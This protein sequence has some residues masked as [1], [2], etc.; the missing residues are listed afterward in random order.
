M[1]VDLVQ[2][3]FEAETSGLVKTEAGLDKVTAAAGRVDA[4]MKKAGDGVAASVSQAGQKFDALNAEIARTKAQAEALAKVKVDPVG[5]AVADSMA[6]FSGATAQAGQAA[7][8]T[9]TQM[10][11][12]TFQAN[13]VFTSIA[14]GAPAMQVLAQQGGQ[15]YQA[16]SMGPGGAGGAIRALSA[17]V[18]RFAVSGPG[19]F[20]AAALSVGAY[21][22]AIE[23]A[24]A[25]QEKLEKQLS[26]GMGRFAGVTADQFR[27]I[28]SAAASASGI[29]RGV[30]RDVGMV[31]AQTG[32]VGGQMLGDLISL[33]KRYAQTTGKEMT[34]AA[35]DI[36]K[37]FTD[38][39][40]GAEQ[41][42][43]TLGASTDFLALKTRDY[44]KALVAQGEFTK[45]QS[46]LFNELA[47]GPMPKLETRVK[48]L[49]TLWER[50]KTAASN[51][52]DSMVRAVVTTPEDRS[53]ELQS[54][55]LGLNKSPVYDVRRSKMQQEL[56][57]LYNDIDD[58]DAKLLA[59]TKARD[60]ELAA[61][62]QKA[63]QQRA[64]AHALEMRAIAAK[65]DVER[66][67][68]AGLQAYN[69]AIEQG[70]GPQAAKVMQINAEEKAYAGLIASINQSIEGYRL[71]A[72]AL[73]A[74]AR[75]F[76]SGGGMARANA[77]MQEANVL[78]KVSA[79]ITAAQQQ[80]DKASGDEK[81][82]LMQRVEELTKKYGEYSVALEQAKVA[83]DR[84]TAAA[85]TSNQE[86]RLEM[87]NLEIRTLNS[88][89]EA[90]YRK[91]EALKT[92]QWIANNMINGNSA[93]AD[94]V[95]ALS[96]AIVDK[97]LKLD[98]ARSSVDSYVDSLSKLKTAAIGAGSALQT[99]FAA[100]FSGAGGAQTS[101]QLAVYSN[102][103]ANARAG[104]SAFQQEA[105]AS[106]TAAQSELQRAISMLERSIQNM[107]GRWENYQP[108]PYA[109][110]N[111]LVFYDV[112]RGT[113]YTEAERAQ[114]T[115]LESQLAT[116]QK[117]LAELQ[118]IAQ[119]LS[120][121]A[122]QAFRDPMT[123]RTDRN[124]GPSVFDNFVNV[125][126]VLVQRDLASLYSKQLY[127]FA[128]GGSMM[129][130]GNPGRDNNVLSL[131]GSPIAKV[132]RGERLDVLTPRQQMQGAGQQGARPPVQDN[133]QF[134]FNI[135]R[136][137]PPPSSARQW[138]D[139]RIA[140]ERLLRRID[141]R[142]RSLAR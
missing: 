70:L 90:R 71:Q 139:E 18:A 35:Q 103:Y 2:V 72:D 133:R 116:Q 108:D 57:A 7:R 39:A 11:Q 81:L 14:S 87:L 88:S 99:M 131:N 3:G 6:R 15:V 115:A 132:S 111:P 50:V 5:A 123:F 129:L 58:L 135:R 42:A 60:A 141:Q 52:G 84:M 83:Q 95:R 125:G 112:N 67:A 117:Q 41:M 51:A 59:D 54:G 79:E 113:R 126:G 20:A 19:A 28:T 94:S 138:E 75:A 47:T 110:K 130:G 86:Q 107:Q 44:I 48:D 53:K 8:L 136:E 16:L 34:D 92:E 102:G 128:E 64:D 80:A 142:V 55:I 97:Q 137:G 78:G 33:T 114:I 121:P 46:V 105:Q 66:A 119:V 85:M 40:K 100:A 76:S 23:R 91:I 31:F 10:Q 134:H 69:Q 29:S 21:V 73:D 4:A 93:A 62:A 122:N 12:L 26:Y 25:E 140:D 74:G 109:E 127:G 30:A 45:A 17:S 89:T 106:N 32:Q 1:A 82:K 38:P 37:A 36:A 120:M 24:Q 56:A 118:R 61:S 77:A 104:Y 68:I 43:A 101:G 96:Q 98:R 22:I 13:D 27:E 63:M 124:M 9:A 65:T 49:A